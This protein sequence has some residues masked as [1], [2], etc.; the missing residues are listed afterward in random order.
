MVGQAFNF[1]GAEGAVLIGNPA[2]LMSQTFTI[3]AWI[4]R[5]S[6]T[7]ASAGLGG[8]SI[9]CRSTPGDFGFLLEND[10]RLFLT[11]VGIDSVFSSSVQVNDT[12]FHHV[13]VTKS[14]TTVKFYVDGVEEVAPPYV[15]VFDF[16]TNAG[17]GARG[18]ISF[19]TGLQFNVFLGAIDE[20]AVY[21][22]VLTAAEIQAIFEAGSAGKCKQ[23]LT[24]VGGTLT[25]LRPARIVC[26]NLTTHKHVVIRDHSPSWS[27]EAAGLKV[28][29]GDIIR[30]TILGGV[31]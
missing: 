10:G 18:D 14:G 29:P 13:A 8:G 27:C 21:N 20:L 7:Q 12:E 23:G 3:E 26:R 15:P 6:S 11:R 17:I 16:T 2:N 22:R 28:T 31:N 24:G 4:K 5:A 19:P 25:G 9:L 30:I 1:D